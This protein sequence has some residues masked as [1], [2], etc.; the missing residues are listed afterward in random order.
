MAIQ[1]S[2]EAGPST[3]P[4]GRLPN[5]KLCH[6]L[7][8]HSRAVTACCFSADGSELIS[9]GADGTVNI[10][11]PKVGAHKSS[12][13]AHRAGIN[14]ISL[15][16]DSLYLA[17]ASDDNTILVFHTTST[18]TARHPT[19]LRRL[20]GHTAPVLS[21]A[22]SPKSNLVVSGSI[23]ESAIIW[24]VRGGRVLRTLPAHSDMVWTVGW[25]NEGGMVITGSADGLIRLWDASTGQCLKTLDNES[26]SPFSYA[27][28]T[29]SS[30][31]LLSSTLSSTIRIHNIYTSKVLKTLRAPGTLV[32]ERFPCPVVIIPALE[33]STP[34][35][36]PDKPDAPRLG[37]SV[38]S[39]AAWIGSGSENGKFVIWELS[40]RRVIQVLETPEPSTIPSPIVAVAASP[41]GRTIVTGHLEPEKVIR[42][43]RDD[44]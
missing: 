39:R 14:D 7:S 44:A 20:V 42:I 33:G 19:P 17:T 21:V 6:S 26:N 30:T 9:A 23:D 35:D 1:P 18:S 43:W 2:P 25:D 34:L 13:Q 10:W 31:F 36:R 32:S 38:D 40:S 8:G 22:F 37:Y 12:F 16:P 29:P 11:D 24:D 5:Y 15:S 3:P 27:A 28:F 4:N 41:D